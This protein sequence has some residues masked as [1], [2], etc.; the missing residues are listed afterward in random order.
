MNEW[1]QYY[2]RNVQKVPDGYLISSTGG[3][4]NAENRGLLFYDEENKTITRLTDTGYGYLTEEYQHYRYI[5]SSYGYSHVIDNTGIVIGSTGGNLEIWY[6]S[7]EDKS[8]SKIASGASFYNW[9]NKDNT[10]MGMNPSYGVIVFDK[11]A[12]AKYLFM[13]QLKVPASSDQAMDLL[14]RVDS[15][16]KDEVGVGHY[17]IGG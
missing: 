8:L 1:F 11:D 17:S 15:I 5:R 14:D 10:I 2:S 3:S 9:I 13:L 12:K 7:F 4:S 16:L 6:Y